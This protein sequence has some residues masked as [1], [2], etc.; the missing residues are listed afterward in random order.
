MNAL[1]RPHG[2]VSGLR[3]MVVD[4]DHDVRDALCELLVDEGFQVVGDAPDGSTA[5]SLARDRAPDVVLVDYRMPGMDGLEA[6]NQM[7]TQAP[8]LQAVM[9]TAYED[10]TLNL[11]AE[12]ADV[13]CLLVKGCS[14]SLILDM[15]LRAATYK[16]ELES[17]RR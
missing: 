11:E 3:V 15:V 6:V 10:E 13:Y 16:R 4:D 14:P 8:H 1:K 9:L 17:R 7:K 12:R 5:V 2:V